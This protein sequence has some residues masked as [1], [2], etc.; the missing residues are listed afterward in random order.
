MLLH[1]DNTHFLVYCNVGDTPACFGWQFAI[2]TARS[3]D[4]GPWSS[5]VVVIVA[6]FGSVRSL[7]ECRWVMVIVTSGLSHLPVH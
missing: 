4:F 7:G 2:S 6:A 3:S 1:D 5:V